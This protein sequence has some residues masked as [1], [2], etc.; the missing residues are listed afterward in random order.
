MRPP[1]RRLVPGAGTAMPPRL[2]RQG[3]A[4]GDQMAPPTPP[5]P[6]PQAQE[7]T[8]ADRRDGGPATPPKRPL[9][10]GRGGTTA[11]A[12]A[13]TPSPLPADAVPAAPRTAQTERPPQRPARGRWGREPGR[14]GPPPP[15]SAALTHWQPTGPRPTPA[16][17]RQP[18]RHEYTPGGHRRQRMAGGRPTGRGGR[19]AP[20]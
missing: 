16:A 6:P 11:E 3:A 12:G 20:P 19:G 9:H 15:P 1:S 14:G 8:E 13:R 18:P 7:Q 4:P 2:G 5:P 17:A 10:P